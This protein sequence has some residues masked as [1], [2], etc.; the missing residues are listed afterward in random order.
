MYTLDPGVL[1]I[2]S[3]AVRSIYQ[4]SISSP[5]RVA[6]PPACEV[7]GRQ[8]LIQCIG[9]IGTRK[10]ITFRPMLS[11][12]HAGCEIQCATGGAHPSK[13]RFCGSSRNCGR[14]RHQ[15]RV[16]RSMVMHSRATDRRSASQMLGKITRST[17]RPPF[18]PPVVRVAPSGFQRS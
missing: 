4:L 6:G 18:G 1:S 11:P 3:V 13:K 14:S 15:R 12:V 2:L 8:C 5:P 7:K 10:R 9:P 17:P 16:R